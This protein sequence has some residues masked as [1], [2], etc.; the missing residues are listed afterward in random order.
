MIEI[1]GPTPAPEGQEG[2]DKTG[3]GRKCNA[4]PARAVGLAEQQWGLQCRRWGSEG[5]E[6]DE[7]I[8]LH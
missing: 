3:K 8:A 4:A 1:P 6:E 2:G 7:G 5:A